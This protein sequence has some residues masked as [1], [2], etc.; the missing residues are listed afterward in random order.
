MKR[1]AGGGGVVIADFLATKERKGT[2]KSGY[3]VWGMGFDRVW[4]D[5]EG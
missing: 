1:L 2:Q 4:G 5:G 3:G